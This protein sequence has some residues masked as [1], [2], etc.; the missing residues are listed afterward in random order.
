MTKYK[1]RSRIW[2]ETEDNVFLG[3]GRVRLLRMIQETGSLSKAAVQLKM[4]YKKAWTLLDSTNRSAKQPITVAS[5]GGKGG[6]GVALTP[7]GIKMIEAFENLNERC[8]DFL[9]TELRKMEI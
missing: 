4:S 3:E 1:I 8:W 7:Y 9:D 5:T 6:G 2:L